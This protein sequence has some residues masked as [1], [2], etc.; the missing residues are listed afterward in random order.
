M[1]GDIDQSQ[2]V[3]EAHDAINVSTLRFLLPS[4]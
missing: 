2:K 3:E 1:Y 4:T